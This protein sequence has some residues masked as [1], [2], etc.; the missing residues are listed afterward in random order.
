MLSEMS[1][2]SAVAKFDLKLMPLNSTERFSSRVENYV[3]YRPGYPTQII[4]IMKN[5]CGLQPEHVIAD[6]AS[7]TGIFTRLLLENGNRVFAVE[8]NEA[9]RKAGN[10]FLA[11]YKNISSINGTAEETS[12]YAHTI[13]FVTAAQAAHWFD[14][15]KAR[16]E[17]IRILKPE[18]WCVLVWNSRRLESSPFQRD[19]EHLISTYGGD[20][21]AVR[22]ERTTDKIRD[23][24]TP[25]PYEFRSFA[26]DQKFDYLSL[27]GRLLSSS[28]IPQTGDSHK[29]MIRELRRI[30]ETYQSNG[31]VTMEYDTHMYY[32]QLSRKPR[33]A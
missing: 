17:F 1:K 6:I 21:Q 32:G 25:A 18:G 8:P 14:R 30:F 26:T 3:R 15:E 5:E 28:Y 9:M 33:A 27:E 23:F 12:L 11:Q 13:D 19:Y 4:E 22:H 10:E 29:S 2:P 20:Y 31:Q 24:F 16:Q 7:G